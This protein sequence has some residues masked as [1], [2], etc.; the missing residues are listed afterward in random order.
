M[1]PKS[2][3]WFSRFLLHKYDDE[4][5]IE[6]F[7]FTKKEV[8]HLATLLAPVIRKQDTKYRF[9]VLVIVCLDC[10]LFKLSHGASFLIY[11]EMFAM[12]RSIVSMML[13]EFVHVVNVTLRNEIM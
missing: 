11:S 10:T 13:W 5:W 1:K 8:F 2:T 12:G 6:M 9:A 4:R 7:C 3:T